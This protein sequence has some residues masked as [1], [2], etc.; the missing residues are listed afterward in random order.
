MISV[1][2][3]YNNDK[4]LRDVLLKSLEN[5]TA[6]FELITLDNTANRF[7][8][9]AEALNYG[10]LKAKGDYIMFVHQDMWF[11]SNSWLEEAERVLASILDLGI[12]GVAGMTSKGGSWQESCRRS[13]EVLG[14]IWGVDRVQR[15]EE[16]QT[17][18]EC[19]LI[20]PRSVFSRIKFDQTIF[21]GWHCYGADYCLNVTELGL[22]AYVIPCPSCHHSSLRTNTEGLLKY[23]AMLYAKHKKR[24]KHIY[25]LLGDY[26]WQYIN[27]WRVK[28]IIGSPYH[29]CF[30]DL[31][32]ILKKEL[33]DCDT[34]LDLGCGNRSL[35]ASAGILPSTGLSVGV[36]LFE[37]Y[38]LDSKRRGIH[39]QY[40]KADIRSIEFTQKAFDAIVA[41][42][43]LEHMTKE[44]G[45]ELLNRMEKWARQKVL[46]S[47]SNGYVQQDA[48]D[49]NP[50]Q[51]HKSGWTVRELR[52]FGFKVFGLHGWKILRDD[53]GSIKYRP[54]LLW[55]IINALTQK[56]TYYNPWLAFQLVAI[57]RIDH[58]D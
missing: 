5:Q 27:V 13:I 6:E 19:L 15:P 58:D 24:Y 14:G 25:T 12:A 43:L 56:I 18:D 39:S 57:K 30:P 33:S 29:R 50:L 11:D 35:L 3:V 32:T 7:K 42:E 37:P 2:C 55:R 51:E 46:I 47:T 49:N 22:K 36:D 44:E 52:R 34:V 54:T 16:V 8:S 17:L 4:I 41:I 48:C 28:K 9:A 23:Q 1:V 53:R 45:S 40:V 10:G 31:A 21:D 20:V 26:S 38:L